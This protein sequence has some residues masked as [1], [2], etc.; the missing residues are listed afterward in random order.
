MNAI[1]ESFVDHVKNNRGKYS[2]LG[3]GATGLGAIKLGGEGYL[4]TQVQDTIH[5]LVYPITNKLK[6]SEL[7]SG[8]KSYVDPYIDVYK[9]TDNILNGDENAKL[10]AV[11]NVLQKEN[12]PAIGAN[13]GNTILSHLVG[14]NPEEKFN[15][16]LR[17]PVDG[18]S[19]K[20]DE[21][22]APAKGTIDAIN[23]FND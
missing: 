2:A 13:I 15:Y 21:M 11:E 17:N 3:A 5:D 12:I 23:P 10:L 9:K 1:L 16:A 6:V 8:A 19:R 20:M 7:E 14:L 4:G 22:K 18:I